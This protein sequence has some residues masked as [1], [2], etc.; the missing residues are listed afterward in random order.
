M[1]H[2]YSELCNNYMYLKHSCNNI[3]VLYF[4]KN[5]KKLTF[6]NIIVDNYV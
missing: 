2:Y 5:T 1:C 4:L 6:L 3:E